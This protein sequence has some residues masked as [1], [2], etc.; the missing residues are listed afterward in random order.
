VRPDFGITSSSII[1]L[2]G[3]LL[4]GVLTLLLL[5]RNLACEINPVMRWAYEGSPM[6]FMIAK[7]VLV[8]AGL[9]LL[10]LVREEPAAALAEKGGAGL[11]AV[12]VAYHVSCL[13]RIAQTGY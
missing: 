6:S 12:I 4:D 7:L 5:Q 13:A 9:L 11:Y 8:Q 10:C 3:N 2:L 1:L